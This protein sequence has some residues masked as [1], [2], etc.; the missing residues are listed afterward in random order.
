M[1]CAAASADGASSVL[2]H[3]DKDERLWERERASAG[4]GALSMRHPTLSTATPL[5]GS[6]SREN[7]TR[8]MVPPLK[9]D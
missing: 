4:Q 7:H 9:I 3:Y 1:R 6:V 5:K 8:R 2:L